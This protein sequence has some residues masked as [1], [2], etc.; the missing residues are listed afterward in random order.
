MNTSLF[1]VSTRTINTIN[2]RPVVNNI[3]KYYYNSLNR[4][5]GLRENQTCNST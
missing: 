5:K 2:D 1:V 3:T 4:V